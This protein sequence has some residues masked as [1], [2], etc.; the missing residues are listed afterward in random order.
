LAGLAKARGSIYILL[1][2]FIWSTLGLF[3]RKSGADIPSFIFYSN[4]FASLMLGAIVMSPSIRARIPR[5]RR[6]LSL[7]AVGPI[8]LANIFTFFY[9]LKH[10]S[11]SNALMTHYIAPVIVAVLAAVFLRERITRTVLFSLALASI[12]LMMLI[13]SGPIG[14][15][16]ALSG[17]ELESWGIA[18]GLASG[19]AY[20]VLI[21]YVRYLATSEHPMVLGFMQTVMVALIMLPF[22]GPV[23]GKTLLVLA[24][25]GALNSTLAVWLYFKGIS[26]VTANRAAILGYSEPVFAIVLG[27]FFLSE[28]PGGMSILG[29]VLIAISGLIVIFN[30]SA[31]QY[32]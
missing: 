13:R 16:S 17:P 22:A 8:T 29:S 12:G 1:A 15:I 2:L 26:L 23:S 3:I 28:V 7:L 18:S 5:G 10:T 21:V 4:A 27:V 11:I 31:Q 14:F 20:A 32:R 19:L 30:S 6:I 24:L 9:A 25:S